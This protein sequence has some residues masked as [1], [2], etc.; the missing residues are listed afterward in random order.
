MPLRLKPSLPPHNPAG[1]KLEVR[2]ASHL[3]ECGES[4]AALNFWSAAIYCRF[5]FAPRLV[6]LLYISDCV[7]SPRRFRN[8][9]RL[10]PFSI[11]SSPKQS[12]ATPCTPY[13][14]FTVTHRCPAQDEKH[15][16]KERHFLSSI[17]VQMTSVPQLGPVV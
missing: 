9:T 1:L 4:L 10:V 3:L 15:M 14:T 12:I 2:V 8:A 5:N 13:H 16:I 17:L 7:E 6:S 11:T